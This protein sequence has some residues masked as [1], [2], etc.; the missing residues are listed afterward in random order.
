MT[1]F[2][3]VNTWIFDLDNTLY[4]ASCKLFDQMHVRMGDYVMKRFGVE[5]AEAKRI[6]KDLYLRHGT[7]LRGLM[8]EHGEAPE[9]FLDAVHDIDYSPVLHSP[10]LRAA[11]AALPGRRLVFTNGTTQH[12]GRVMEKLGVSDLF[13]A[14][15]DVVDCGYVPK[16]AASPYGIF[17]QRH[18]VDAKRSAFFEDIMHNLE[19]PH[20]LGMATVLV[21]SEESAPLNPGPV[22]AYV[23]HRTNDLAGFLARLT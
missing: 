11:L 8:V 12:A 16:P 15:F 22:A 20:A 5:Y 1:G 7:T 2:D 14:V 18:K 21:E 17:V 6:Q 3:Q 10:D 4:P 19:V 9:G 13:E 23:Q